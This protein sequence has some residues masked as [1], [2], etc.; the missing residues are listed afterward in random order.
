LICSIFCGSGFFFVA[1]V[2]VVALCEADG[3]ALADPVVAGVIVAPA[4]GV[5][6]AVGAAGV[7][8][9]AAVAAGVVAGVVGA[10]LAVDLAAAAL[11]VGFVFGEVAGLALTLALGAAV[12]VALAAGA[13]GFL[14]RRGWFF[15]VSGVAVG[16]GVVAGCSAFVFGAVVGGVFLLFFGAFVSDFV[17][18]SG[19]VVSGA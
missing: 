6:L 1:A 5:V 11:A 17:V 2:F 8:L 3:A 13:F 10:A 14:L 16:A 12:A 4:A 7:V 18:V 9:A 19:F 15:V